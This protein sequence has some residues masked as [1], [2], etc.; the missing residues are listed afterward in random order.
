MAGIR[1]TGLVSG[2][3]TESLVSQLSEAYQTKVNNVKK[4]Q[5]KLE[6]KKE[7]WTALNT[8]IMDFYKGA[9]STF[10]SVSTYRAKAATGNLTGVKVTAGSDAVNGTHR[11][12]VISTATAQMW[13]SKKINDK[14]YTATSYKAA[15]DGTMKLSDL[16]DNI[17][18][19]IGNQLKN[20]EFK[21]SAN[22]QEY[23]VKAGIDENGNAL[24]DDATVDDIVANINR[25]L[26]GSGVKV[27]FAAG[28][29]RMS[30]E[31]A[32][33]SEIQ[34]DTGETV[35]V[36]SG[37]YD[38]KVTAADDSTAKI[39]G[40]TTNEEGTLIESK[41]SDADKDPVT[42]IGGATKFYQEI[43]T[44]DAKVTANTK[45]VDLGIAEGTE[46]KINGNAITVDRKTTLKSLA[47]K[48]AKL[49]IEA[50]YDAGQG[51]FYLN[52]KGT[53]EKNKF[54]VDAD[55]DTLAK[56]GLDLQE[57]DEGRIDA[58]NAVIE[59]N[60][61]R[62]EQASS[63]F[64]INGL[65]IEATEEGETQTFNVGTDSKGI[66]D[67]VKEFVKSYNDLIE[68]MNTLY[69][70]KRVKDYEPLTEDEK[71]AMSDEEVEKW[72]GV[73]KASLL[74]RDDT[75]NSLLSS[76]RSTLNKQ[77]SV[78]L[79]DGTKKNYSLTSFGINTS[80][81]TERGKLHIYGDEDDADFMD[82]DN[83]LMA[84]I[85]KNPSAVEKTF[86]TLGSEIYNNLLKAMNSNRDLSS[87]LTFYNDK[88]LDKEIDN[89][90]DRVSTL[91]DKALAEEDKYYK[92]F[93]AMESA[94]AKLQSQQTYISQLFGG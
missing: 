10:R 51:R 49:G 93:A 15:T 72:E 23:T 66:Y 73:I 59:Y 68:E 48:M 50:N 94:L 78:T 40:I 29:F 28:N 18:N 24:G 37:G 82:F 33:Q 76:M 13:T 92:Q 7:A 62:Y 83:E 38:V 11:V 32:V 84:A 86:S 5:T 21:V 90:K 91:Q 63:T 30:N 25:Q 89:Y 3:D 2:L 12:K 79:S 60:G 64:S 6:W 44:A 65:T 41:T 16:K 42:T 87:A 75:I 39:F 58:K 47:E 8:K 67:K 43:E 85:N 77:V 1:M 45:L 71:A 88:Q 57:G 53:G 20:A 4:Q 26:E 35:T 56:L 22:G 17:G 9:L 70:A 54:T 34:N 14:T 19:S 31:S 52:A 80:V 27:D 46:I 74:R 81:Y 55:S 61:V 69:N 36:F